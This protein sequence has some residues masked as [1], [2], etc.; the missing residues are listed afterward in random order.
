MIRIRQLKVDINNNDIKDNINQRLCINNNDILSYEIKKQSID[1]RRKPNIY[2]IYEVDVKVN[3]EEK[4]LRYNKDK[5]IL[6]AP[7]E[8]YE[9]KITGNKVLN[10]RPIIVG[11]GPAGLYAAYLLAEHNYNPLIIERGE[12]VDNR[13]KKVE[14]FWNNNKLDINSNVQFGEGGAGPFSDGKLTTLV[15]A[16]EYRGKKVFE[17]FVSCGAPKEIM[18]LNKPHIGTD[19][20]RTV[21]KNMRNKII[22]M[23][24]E[25]RY[26]T[27]LT[28]INIVNNKI[29][30]IVV[31][32]SETINTDVLVLAIGHSARDTFEM[33]YNKK[34]YMEPKPFA[35]GIRIS[36]SQEMI[37]KSQ[38]G[39]NEL[40]PASYKL[41]HTCKNGRG[42]YTFCMCPGGYVVNSSSEV[43]R[44]AINGMSNYKRESDNANSAIIVTVS[45]KDYGTNPMDGI[46]YQ[47]QL[48]EKAYKLGNGNIPIQLYKDFKDN[49]V[50]TKLGSVKPIFKGNYT[51]A[52]IN[53]I[54]PNYITESLKEGIDAFNNQIK[55]FSNDDAIIAAIES[56]TSSPI[57]I[58]RNETGI[59]NIDGIYPIG[60][61]AGYAGGITSVAMDGIKVAENIAMIYKKNA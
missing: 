31:N 4:I 49:K 51:F 8:I 12:D 47:R 59:S 1:S 10:N 26:N 60:E 11:S 58:V 21:V 15:T 48:E 61:G 25:F 27:T 39:S 45:P 7:K 41:T 46:K 40:G 24:G 20:L 54:L 6:V 28:D 57:R 32:N 52:N 23:G 38:Y 14:E 53:D 42:V 30:S 44:L 17:T 55:G 34:I 43:G 36:H 18:Y 9:F 2:Y 3:N 37:N 33:L 19:I 13:C 5:D 50:T 22:S 16:K 56:R 29:K 35:L